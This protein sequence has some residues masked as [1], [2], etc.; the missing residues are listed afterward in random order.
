M[1]DFGG[2]IPAR[3]VAPVP[4]LASIAAAIGRGL[5]RLPYRPRHLCAEPGRASWPKAV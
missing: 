5:R 1:L 4:T 3:Y 2:G